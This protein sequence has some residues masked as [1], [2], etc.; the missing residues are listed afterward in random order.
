MQRQSFSKWMYTLKAAKP[1]QWWRRSI[2]T[3]LKINIWV[4]MFGFPKATNTLCSDLM[5]HLKIYNVVFQYDQRNELDNHFPR[6]VYF[7]PPIFSFSVRHKHFINFE[8][9]KQAAVPL[10][11]CVKRTGTS[12]H[13]RIS[14]HRSD[15]QTQINSKD[16]HTT[17]KPNLL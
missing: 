16:C 11:S 17:A 3:I 2:V 8:T 1:C 9:L 7:Q 10:L 15:V 12:A 5:F 13:N 14:T 6:T 4:Y